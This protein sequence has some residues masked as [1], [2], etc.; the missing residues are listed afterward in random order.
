MFLYTIVVS[1]RQ[2][3]RLGSA[4][5]PYD[6][7]NPHNRQT[8]LKDYNQIWSI[9]GMTIQ[10]SLLDGKHDHVAHAVDALFGWFLGGQFWLRHV[11]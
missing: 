5:T 11:L 2:Q 9:K 7:H 10:T 3:R 1:S 4:S 8:R 6:R